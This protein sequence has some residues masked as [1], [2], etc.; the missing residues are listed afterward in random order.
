MK[1]KKIKFILI[2]LVVLFLSPFFIVEGLYRLEIFRAKNVIKVPEPK[3]VSPLVSQAI[4]ACFDEKGQPDLQPIY[5]WHIL[6]FIIFN[7]HKLG[8]KGLFLESFVAENFPARFRERE[9]MTNRH[10]KSAALTIWISRNWTIEQAICA[11]EE[12]I[13]DEGVV[14][15]DNIA[16]KVAKKKI[17]EMNIGELSSLLAATYTHDPNGIALRKKRILKQMYENGA[18]AESEFK[19]YGGE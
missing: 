3:Q 8:K 11:A 19:K 2:F 7:P 5:P 18:I 17:D 4:W 13:S 1:N 6:S 12:S 14:G 15:L 16:L 10:L 9:N